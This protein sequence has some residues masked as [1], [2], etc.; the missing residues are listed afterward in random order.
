M[1]VLATL[2]NALQLSA[3]DRELLVRAAKAA[4]GN[5]CPA[6]VSPP[7][8]RVRQSVRLVLDRLE[9]TPAAGW[10][11]AGAVHSHSTFGTGVV[12]I[13]GEYRP[14]GQ[15]GWFAYFRVGADVDNADSFRLLQSNT[16]AAATPLG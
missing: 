6:Q 15:A 11:T 16:V 5:A 9:P 12:S 3:G 8:W 13:V 4:G 1:Q 14:V 10:L 2:A 7:A